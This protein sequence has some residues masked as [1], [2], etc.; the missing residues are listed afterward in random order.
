MILQ[1]QLTSL[2]NPQG[3]QTRPPVVSKHVSNTNADDLLLPCPHFICLITLIKPGCLARQPF[4][5][6]VSISQTT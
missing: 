5:V 1:L 3:G 6:S 4:Y 2:S